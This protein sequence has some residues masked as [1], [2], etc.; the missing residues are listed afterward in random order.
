VESL[1]LIRHGVQTV[2]SDDPTLVWVGA[3]STARAAVELCESARPDVVLVSSVSDPG[4]NLCQL[5]ARLFKN[6]TVVALLGREART[7]DVIARARI[8]GVQSLVPLDADA[9]RLFAAIRLGADLGHFVDPHLV[10]VP[11]TAQASG[12][13]LRKP[14]SKR[15]FEVLQLVAEGRTAVQIGVRLNIAADTVRTHMSHILRKL[16][17]RDRA[18]AVAKAFRM[19]L[20]SK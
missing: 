8:H 15:E 1:P 7:P 10:P 5:L 13:P 20:L 16:E 9:E 6:L 12:F 17:A 4:W 11:S 2:V 14:L 18:H 3:V 19:S